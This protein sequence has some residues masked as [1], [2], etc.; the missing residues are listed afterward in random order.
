MT[1]TTGDD[2]GLCPRRAR[3][4]PTSTAHL[5]NCSL[6]TGCVPASFKNSFVTLILKKA[7]LDEASP[8]SYKP[9]SNLS[10]ISKTLECL[11]ARQFVM[12]LDATACCRQLN[13]A[14]GGGTPQ[15]LRSF[16]CS[17]IS[18]MLWTATTP[19]CLLLNL[20]A[21]FDSV[22]HGILLELSLIHI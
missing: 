11:V 1:M 20:S 8:S 3:S 16:V 4:S 19:P 9:M 22:D 7:G 17:R 15:K 5:F 13:P 10:V 14:S 18:W 6:A 12:Y 21:A 2:D